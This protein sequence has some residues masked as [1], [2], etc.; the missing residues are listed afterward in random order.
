MSLDEKHIS[1]LMDKKNNWPSLTDFNDR[2]ID[3]GVRGFRLLTTM[4]FVY[5]PI[6]PIEGQK[7]G[8]LMEM[9]KCLELFILKMV[10]GLLFPIKKALETSMKKHPIIAKIG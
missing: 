4:N 5:I 1:I 6:K 10:S 7:F 3:G 9:L 8:F 2:Y